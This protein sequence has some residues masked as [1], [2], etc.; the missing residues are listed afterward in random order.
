MKLKAFGAGIW[1]V[2]CVGLV[3]S[4]LAESIN[5]GNDIHDLRATVLCDN[6][7]INGEFD[8]NFENTISFPIQS[9]KNSPIPINFRSLYI[10]AAS[11]SFG[12][13]PSD[14]IG[15]SIRIDAQPTAQI[16][17]FKETKT[18]T[19]SIYISRI[20][21]SNENAEINFYSTS[22]RC[23]MTFGKNSMVYLENNYPDMEEWILKIKGNVHVVGVKGNQEIDI[24]MENIMIKFSGSL[25][26]ESPG[27]GNQVDLRID[28]DFPKDIDE[29]DIYKGQMHF[30]S[31][32]DFSPNEFK[33]ESEGITYEN[34]VSEDGFR[35]DMANNFYRTDFFLKSFRVADVKEA[36][37]QEIMVDQKRIS[38]GSHIKYLGK[39]LFPKVKVTTKYFLV[40]KNGTIGDPLMV[41]SN[42]ESV[43][44]NNV[45]EIFVGRKYKI[46]IYIEKLVKDDIIV[47][48]CDKNFEGSKRE[49]GF[50]I[51]DYDSYYIRCAHS[52]SEGKRIECF[53]EI[54][55][56]KR[57]QET[58]HRYITESFF[59]KI[60]SGIEFEIDPPLDYESNT[61]VHENETFSISRE[62][63]LKSETS[64]PIKIYVFILE[65]GFRMESNKSYF[66]GSLTEGESIYIYFQMKAPII[67]YDEERHE[68]RIFIYY[69]MEGSDY[70]TLYSFDFSRDA[71]FTE[72]IIVKRNF[73]YYFLNSYRPVVLSI[74]SGIISVLLVFSP[75][76]DA[77]TKKICNI[78]NTGSDSITFL[79]KVLL[80]TVIFALVTFLVSYVFY[81]L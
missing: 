48:Y 59:A 50:D 3:H 77:I 26:I 8:L 2:M 22:G 35:V 45:V 18:Y 23:H 13:N 7:K 68:I 31:N 80:I 11:I 57:D 58:S 6:F 14:N 10:D 61:I 66:T 73:V 27:L 49:Y 19:E 62:I 12:D 30:I 28:F 79:V 38:V 56:R 69:Q 67:N 64:D 63:T 60:E 52:S 17:F 21:N 75:I 25:E 72:N 54:I 5:N 34:E 81:R 53:T 47:D 78:L 43:S 55:Y 33:V 40:S 15:G 4:V 76:I 42:T 41:I 36:E 24:L 1:L 74:L 39:T 29:F 51:G 37:V 44:S 71:T 20:T 16:Y 65:E 46:E 70:Y 32:Y 9:S